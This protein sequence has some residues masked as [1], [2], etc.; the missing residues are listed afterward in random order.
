MF[1][2]WA[3]NTTLLKNFR[4]S[5]VIGQRDLGVMLGIEQKQAQPRISHYENGTR[6]FPIE[7]AYAFID[8]AKSKG[9][10]FTL[11]D[12]YPRDISEEVA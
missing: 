8:L 11:E 1:Y 3:M 12:I 4:E 10:T 5:H 9:E 2:Y 7:L 6:E